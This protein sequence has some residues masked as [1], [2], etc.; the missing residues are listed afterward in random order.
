MGAADMRVPG[1]AKAGPLRILF[2]MRN[3][4]YVKLFDSVIRE[5]ASRGI[6]SLVVTTHA[7][8]RFVTCSLLGRRPA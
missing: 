3:F 4:W 5:L 1:A 2:S 7:E 6:T 8:P